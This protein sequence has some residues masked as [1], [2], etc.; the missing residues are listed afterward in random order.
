MLGIFMESRV[1]GEV[2]NFPFLKTIRPL[3]SPTADVT[4]VV[5]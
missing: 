4:A 2:S 1:K 3:P 5:L